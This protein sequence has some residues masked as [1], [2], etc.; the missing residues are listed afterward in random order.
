VP[1]EDQCK[2]REGEGPGASQNSSFSHRG[3]DGELQ[4]VEAEGRQWSRHD[5]PLARPINRVLGEMRSRGADG[6]LACRCKKVY[7]WGPYKNVDAP[8]I[9]FGVLMFGGLRGLVIFTLGLCA[10]GAMRVH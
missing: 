1:A 7:F 8:S 4:K 6:Y 2:E 5:T 10:L 3:R 9:D